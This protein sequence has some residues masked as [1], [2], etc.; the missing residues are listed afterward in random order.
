MT[1][2][3]PT[4]EI[5]RLAGRRSGRLHLPPGVFQAAGGGAV[6]RAG[7]ALRRHEGPVHTG[8]CWENEVVAGGPVICPCQ[9]RAL[10]RT[11]VKLLSVAGRLLRPPGPL[12]GKGHVVNAVVPLPQA[13]LEFQLVWLEALRPEGPQP[14]VDVPPQSRGRC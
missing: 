7:A 2:T 13:P 9:H 12:R 8:K 14:H 5:G 1:I 11:G 6:R 10:V 4:D 3:T